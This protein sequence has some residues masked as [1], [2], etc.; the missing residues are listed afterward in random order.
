M[1]EHTGLD[2]A[3]HGIEVEMEVALFPVHLLP[4]KNW[5]ILDLEVFIDVSTNEKINPD[6][7]VQFSRLCSCAS[8]ASTALEL[9]HV[10]FMFY[11]LLHLILHSHNLIEP[12]EKKPSLP[13]NPKLG[14][15]APICGPALQEMQWKLGGCMRILFLL[16]VCVFFFFFLFLSIIIVLRYH[17]SY[18]A[19][20]QSIAKQRHTGPVGS[21][22]LVTRVGVL[23]VPRDIAARDAF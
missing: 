4:R 11:C 8:S 23:T 2:A 16:C 21:T 15:D 14:T 6:P 3:W 13:Q 22:R 1:K 10:Y 5:I 19:S 17:R 18:H 12:C 9:A 7:A 20:R